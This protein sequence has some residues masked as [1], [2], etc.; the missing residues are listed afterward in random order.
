MGDSSDV[1]ATST[2][3]GP[4]ADN[5]GLPQD[6]TIVRGQQ[7]LVAPRSDRQ[8]NHTYMHKI[9]QA[10]SLKVVKTKDE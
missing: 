1:A 4:A 8:R 2:G 7:F 5:S 10:K 3:S 9:L 6:G